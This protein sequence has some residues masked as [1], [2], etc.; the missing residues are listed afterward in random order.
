MKPILL[1]L[2]GFKLFAYPLMMGIAWGMGYYGTLNQL[3]KRKIPTEGFGKLFLG[4][5]ISSWVG[6]KVFFLINSSAGHVHKYTVNT[7]FWLGGGFVFYG[8]FI[9]GITYI[10]IYCLFFKKF[11][12]KNLYL[13]LPSFTFAHAIGRVGCFLA[14][15]CYG[16]QCS[17]PW[18]VHLHNQTRHPVQ[19]YEVFSLIVVGFILK[20]LIE[21]KEGLWVILNTYVFSYAV[22]RFVLEYFRGD[23]VR[24]TLF[25]DLS[26]SQAISLML[27]ITLLFF[28][29]YRLKSSRA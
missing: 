25:F 15:C 19:L 5:F 1:D 24:G 17:L 14:G 22:I 12:I 10:L 8:G 9:F 27:I 21:K 18:A 13:S 20:K 4:V 6:A 23:K 26:S 3:E 28:N 29:L 11:E 7:N 2:W 16:T